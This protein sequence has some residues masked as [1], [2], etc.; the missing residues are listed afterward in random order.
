MLYSGGG[1]ADVRHS[2]RHCVCVSLRPGRPTGTQ[3]WPTQLRAVA[4][5]KAAIYNA[6]ECR[7]GL[8]IRCNHESHRVTTCLVAN[9][10]THAC[11]GIAALPEWTCRVAYALLHASLGLSFLVLAAM[12]EVSHNGAQP[13]ANDLPGD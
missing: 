3:L 7:R 4:V 12:D 2:A 10:G 8:D 1:G 9:F 13:M 11:R 6:P 5:V